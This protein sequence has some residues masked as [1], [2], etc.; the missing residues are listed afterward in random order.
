MPPQPA[1]PYARLGDHLDACREVGEAR[2]T[3]T[4]AAIEA[5]IGRALPATARTPAGVHDWWFVRR[6]QIQAWEGWLRRGWR[7]EA[8][9]LAAERVT[10]APGR[11]VGRGCA[12]ATAAEIA[13]WL[14]EEFERE[15]YLTQDAAAAGI[16]ARFGVAFVPRGQ[17]WQEVHKAFARLEPEGRIWLPGARA[18]R[19]RN[20]YDPPYHPRDRRTGR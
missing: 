9:D 7:V 10:F 1:T 5:L 18:W 4:F 6:N 12:M 8:V 3:L 2:V 14:L 13:R 20:A 17:L 11:G 19:R 16:R 15:G